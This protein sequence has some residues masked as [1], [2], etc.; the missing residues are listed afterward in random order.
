MFVSV[1]NG[2]WVRVDDP[3]GHGSPGPVV[4]ARFTADDEARRWR[5]TELYV[6]G[7]GEPITGRAL[8]GLPMAA[9]EAVSADPDL[10]AQLGRTAA[11]PAVQVSTLASYYDTTFGGR[12]RGW[13]A[14]SYRCQVPGSGVTPVKRAPDRP[15]PVR[16]DDPP[17][18]TTPPDGRLTDEFLRLVARCYVAAV[19]AGNFPGPALAEQAGVSPRTVQRWVYTARQRGIMAPGIPGAVC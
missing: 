10:R 1:G 3:M 16:P 7:R 5:A 17:P 12:A 15:L 8:R 13:V 6:D 11:L 18:L 2:G 4:Y 19:R 9:I 14:D